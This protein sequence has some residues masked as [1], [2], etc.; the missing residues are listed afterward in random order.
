VTMLALPLGRA[1]APGTVRAWGFNSTG[2]LGDGTNTDSNVPVTVSGLTNVVGVAA[3]RYHSLAVKEDGT[4]WAWGDNSSGQLGTSTNSNLPGAV[5]GL[6]NMVAVAGGAFH[7]LA[8]KADRTVWAWGQNGS[9]QLGNGTNT[10]SYL[11]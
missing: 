5:S 10:N 6:T 3:G 8:L 11:P 7:S 1:Q 4:G 9:G 2:Q